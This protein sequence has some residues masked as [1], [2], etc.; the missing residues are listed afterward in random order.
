MWRVVDYV[1]FH[2]QIWP[3]VLSNLIY[4]RTGH[5]LRQFTLGMLGRADCPRSGFPR[6]LYEN[7]GRDS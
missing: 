5:A 2:G 7:L 1:Y 4:E 3:G 6:R